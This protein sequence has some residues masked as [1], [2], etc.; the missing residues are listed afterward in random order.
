METLVRF[1]LD[2][3]ASN[4]VPSDAQPGHISHERMHMAVVLGRAQM[5]ETAYTIPDA[6]SQG[7]LGVAG[8]TARPRITGS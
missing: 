3:F 6:S 1:R 7:Q 4:G 8:L 5:A 2:T